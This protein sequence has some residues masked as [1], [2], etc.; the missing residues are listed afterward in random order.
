MA[1]KK[2]ASLI[3][4][5]LGPSMKNKLGNVRNRNGSN[6]AADK[7]GTGKRSE[8][9]RTGRKLG[10]RTFPVSRTLKG[11]KR[12][13][14][15][16]N[17]V[18]E[19]TEEGIDTTRK[20]ARNRSEEVGFALPSDEDICPSD[21]NSTPSQGESD[22][23][24]AN[25]QD[26]SEVM[27]LS[28]NSR[29]Q[30]SKNMLSEM[31]V[32]RNSS[33]LIN[34]NE[35]MPRNPNSQNELKVE[36]M[37]ALRDKRAFA[38]A[39]LGMQDQK[40]MLEKELQKVKQQNL[41]LQT[42]LDNTRSSTKG[43]KPV[44]SQENLKGSNI[45][46]YQGICLSSGVLAKKQAVLITTESYCD[47]SEN[48]RKRSWFGSATPINE[49]HAAQYSLIVKLP[50][51]SLAVP[52]CC[53]HRALEGEDYSAEF[54]SAKQFA[55]SCVKQV[56]E[57]PIGSAM[58]HSEKTQ[59]ISRIL[60]HKQT[61]Q[62]FRGILSD[63]IGN[64][65]K[66]SL[67]IYLRTLGYRNGAKSNSKHLTDD[68]RASRLAER[69]MVHDRIVNISVGGDINTMTWRLY[70]S[71]QISNP[72]SDL[73]NVLA[74]SDVSDD[75][76][77]MV[78]HLF[79]NIAAKRAFRCL[80][81][82]KVTKSQSEFVSDVSI[83]C[84]AKADAYMTTM[85]KWI[86]VGG[87]GG[88]RNCD[89]RDDFR[90]MLPIAMNAIIQDVWDDIKSTAPQE[91]YLYI[92]GSKE[93][94]EDPFGNNLR[95]W[96]VVLTHPN[97]TYFYLLAR[98]SYFP[99]MVC[100]WFGNVKDCYIGRCKGGDDLF[101]IIN[102]SMSLEELEESDVEEEEAHNHNSGGQEES[103]SESDNDNVSVDI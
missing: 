45:E 103:E 83:L 33:P 46:E 98:P 66:A 7:Q 87:K 2:G 21:M 100:S 52:N 30:Q 72:T 61:I 78:D 23:T 96:T 63:C 53:M 47:E 82:Y 64:R 86:R 97:D 59:C 48:C 54:K 35:T 79:I 37:E 90:K 89:I 92:G 32:T 12:V 69:E 1:P 42:S 43:R 17:Q 58:S 16:L 34:R 68:E 71:A 57:G 67:Q 77:G 3:S 40:R 18:H 73:S 101:K 51:G 13:S 94:D 28:L 41:A 31:G 44:W 102:S 91:L 65:K 5:P 10:D 8:V 95:E 75:E 88:A 56:L 15:N 19:D 27:P 81:G 70:P 9:N 4:K 11:K 50:N 85:V 29:R 26:V 36:L 6:T 14:P 22:R 76:E 38:A 62:K 25:E 93:C 60:A 84:L 99:K 49:Q 74:D 39:F 80:L 24:A 55:S 20:K